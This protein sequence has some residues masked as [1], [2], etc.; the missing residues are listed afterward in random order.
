MTS[1]ACDWLA[2]AIRTSWE[3]FFFLLN[4]SLVVSEGSLV[5]TDRVTSAAMTC[6]CSLRT[7]SRPTPTTI[8]SYCPGRNARSPTVNLNGTLAVITSY[9]RTCDMAGS[10]RTIETNATKVE[11]RKNFMGQFFPPD[12][13]VEECGE[14]DIGSKEVCFVSAVARRNSHALEHSTHGSCYETHGLFSLRP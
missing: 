13:S 9:V 2:K 8:N 6:R 3:R 7:A 5:S 4:T 10:H 1:N 11:R 12:F 14:V